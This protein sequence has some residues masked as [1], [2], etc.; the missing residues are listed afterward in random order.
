MFGP[1]L[2]ELFPGQHASANPRLRIVTKWFHTLALAYPM[3]E[4]EI[5]EHLSDR[6]LAKGTR[7]QL[8]NIKVLK[9]CLQ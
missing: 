9:L 4:G 1:L 8:E 3:F 2:H 5:K 6:R 7:V